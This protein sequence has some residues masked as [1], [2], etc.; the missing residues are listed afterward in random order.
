MVHGVRKV[1]MEEARMGV[2]D[3][4]AAYSVRDIRIEHAGGVLEVTLFGEG[5]STAVL[6]TEEVKELEP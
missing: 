1:T 4:G 2:T 3:K 6:A 5:A